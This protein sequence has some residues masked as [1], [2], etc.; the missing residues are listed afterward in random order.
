MPKAGAAT[1]VPTNT[2]AEARNCLRESDFS[3]VDSIVNSQMLNIHIIPAVAVWP[4]F[5]HIRIGIVKH[6]LLRV[7]IQWPLQLIGNIDDVANRCGTVSDFHVGYR[8]APFLDRIVPV[9]V[10]IIGMVYFLVACFQLLLGQSSRFGYEE[11]PR[12]LDFPLRADKL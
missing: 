8:L 4:P 3:F 6:F 12:H 10:V 2:D 9:L 1:A 5:E 7:P 11:T